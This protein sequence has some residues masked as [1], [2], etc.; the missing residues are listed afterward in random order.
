MPQA[1][2]VPENPTDLPGRSL[3]RVLRRT[4]SQFHDDKLPTWAA[5]L[6]YY[7]VLS[8]FPAL[9]AL[10]SILGVIGPSATQPLIDQLG[11]VAPG[12]AKDILTNVLTSLQQNQ[13]GSTV[14]LIIGLAAAIWSASGYI[15][16]F[17]DAANNVWDV[18]EGRPI[19]KK[20][21]VRLGVTVVLL[22]LLTI[23]ALAV[24]FTGPVAEKVG[25]LIGL[26]STFVAVWSIAKWPVLLLIVSFMI[27]LLYWA[28]PNV[29]QPGF[30]WA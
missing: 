26:G 14:A 7:A 22:V 12:P 29:K 21:P 11:T 18:E 23:T 27:S 1:A 24:V 16:A 10:V 3:P 25:N 13:G 9:L 19:W 30:P 28:C 6:T 8:I 17:M 5:A 4:V 20:I 15:G 2:A